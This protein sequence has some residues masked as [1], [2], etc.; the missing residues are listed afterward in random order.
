LSLTSSYA[1]GVTGSLVVD[2]A[3][4]GPLKSVSITQSGTGITARTSV[5]Y[6]NSQGQSVRVT[7]G[8]GNHTSFVYD[9][10]GNLLKA[11]GHRAIER[12]WR[13]RQTR[14]P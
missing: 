12:A 5:K 6:T 9:A 13:N 7:D 3:T 1:Y 11:I 8:L 10:I 2:G 4:V 14:W